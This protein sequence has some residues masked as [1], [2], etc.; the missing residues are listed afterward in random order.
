ML[1]RFKA[2][3]GL[4]DESVSRALDID[5]NKSLHRVANGRIDVIVEPT[6]IPES[7]KLHSEL[8]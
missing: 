7:F 3:S 1:F 5:I 4:P 8:R 2:T 6:N